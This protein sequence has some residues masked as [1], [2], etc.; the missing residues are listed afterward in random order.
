MGFLLPVIHSLSIHNH[1]DPYFLQPLLVIISKP[2]ISY[3]T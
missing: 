1:L 3:L 2:K